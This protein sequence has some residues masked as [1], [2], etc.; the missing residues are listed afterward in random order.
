MDLP[1]VYGPPLTSD[2]KQ[3]PTYQV[4][5]VTAI[6]MRHHVTKCDK[7][8]QNYQTLL[9]SSLFHIFHTNCVLT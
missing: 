6:K 7:S 8:Q 3:V 2:T 1:V 4:Y 5:D 9:F